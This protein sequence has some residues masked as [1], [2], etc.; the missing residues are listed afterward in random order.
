MYVIDQKKCNG[1]AS[2]ME[3]CEI[4]A[5]YLIDN[6]AQI[7]QIRCTECGACLDVCP[8]DA[9]KVEHTKEQEYPIVDDSSSR[10]SVLAEVKSS[11]VAVG[12]ALLPLIITKVGDIILSK[13]ENANRPASSPKQNNMNSKRTGRR[14]SHGRGRW[15]R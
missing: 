4:G 2:C 13:L 9:I 10:Q 1:C 8:V 3:I 7:D 6:K 14:R 5:I 12:S 11:V 15:Q